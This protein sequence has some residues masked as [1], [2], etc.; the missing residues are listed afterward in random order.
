MII[1]EFSYSLCFI[2]FHNSFDENIKVTFVHPVISLTCSQLIDTRHCKQDLWRLE[3]EHLLI[4]QSRSSAQLA[5]CQEQTFMIS[6]WQQKTAYY[7]AE[8]GQGN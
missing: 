3:H 4:A 6:F 7:D 5:S 1:T 2:D 8:Y